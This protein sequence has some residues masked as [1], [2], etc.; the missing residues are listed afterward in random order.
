MRLPACWI[1]YVLKLPG[2]A[3]S[4]SILTCP[5]ADTTLPSQVFCRAPR[6]CLSAMDMNIRALCVASLFV[7]G[8]L[9][10]SAARAG[11]TPISPPAKTDVASAVKV[12]L[13]RVGG[14]P[15]VGAS[16]NGSKPYPF[17]VDLAANLFAINPGR[18]LALGLPT[19]GNDEMGNPKVAVADMSISTA[20]FKGL[21][22]AA[23]GFLSG[24]PEAGVLGVN[25]F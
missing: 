19:S 8:N 16:I 5:P 13:L 21:T 14:L 17:I 25:V 24:H 9:T 2:P 12:P 10:G 4:S 7:I 1:S 20:R 6:K 11:D 22:A 23:D 15:A 3:P 18:A